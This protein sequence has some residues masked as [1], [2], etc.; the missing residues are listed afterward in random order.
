MKVVE[1]HEQSEGE[2]TAEYQVVVEKPG[3]IIGKKH[4]LVIGGVRR[5]THNKR[6]VLEVEDEIEV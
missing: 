5:D 2:A 4:L 1:L 3:V 6:L